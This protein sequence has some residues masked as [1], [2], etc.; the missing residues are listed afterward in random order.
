M[1]RT[2]RVAPEIDEASL[3]KCKKAWV[4]RRWRIEATNRQLSRLHHFAKERTRSASEREWG[5]ESARTAMRNIISVPA[6]NR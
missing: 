6:I 5:R 1:P 2:G 4:G 3:K